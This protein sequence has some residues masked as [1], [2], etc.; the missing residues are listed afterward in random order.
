MSESCR[1]VGYNSTYLCTEKSA[2]EVVVGIQA[3]GGA[4]LALPPSSATYHRIAP[5]SAALTSSQGHNKGVRATRQLLQLFLL[6]TDSRSLLPSQLIQLIC[7]PSTMP[8]SNTARACILVQMLPSLTVLQAFALR[9]FLVAPLSRVRLTFVLALAA[10]TCSTV[11][12]FV[13]DSSLR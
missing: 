11:S 2:A 9:R 4:T 5:F 13:W 1:R 12:S 3:R 10:P 6:I 7:P 8:S